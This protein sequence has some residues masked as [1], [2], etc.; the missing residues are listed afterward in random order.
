MTIPVTQLVVDATRAGGEA[1]LALRDR[2][3]EVQSKGFRDEVTDAD[4]AAQEAIFAAIRAHYPEAVIASE[5]ND[6]GKG[7]T[8]WEPPQGRWWLTDPLDGTTNYSRGLPHF[9][10]TVAVLEGWEP[11]GGAIFDPLRNQMFAAVRGGG[12]TLDGQAA[13]DLGAR[14]SGGRRAGSRAGARC[15]RAPPKPG[16]LQHA[17]DRVPDGAHGGRGGPGAGLRRGGLAGG[18]HPPDPTPVGLRGGRADD[19]RGGW[20]GQPPGRRPLDPARPADS[21]QQH[22]DSRPAGGDH[23]AGAGWGEWSREPMR[24]R[25]MVWVVVLLALACG[26]IPAVGQGSLGRIVLL[27][28]QPGG[29]L[30]AVGGIRDVWIYDSDLRQVGHLSNDLTLVVNRLES[31]WK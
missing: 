18:L 11:I 30:I 13:A 10:V 1:L 25:R 19:P 15:G 27:E 28:W 24:I 8:D 12:A 7:I 3:R 14:R 23:A 2:P 16:D 4:Y 9:C 26:A 22:A 5:E 20:G 29:E 21:R 17:G 6:F 31:R